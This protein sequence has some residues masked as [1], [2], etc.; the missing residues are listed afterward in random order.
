MRSSPGRSGAITPHSASSRPRRPAG[1]SWRRRASCSPPAATRRPDRADRRTAGVA[2]DTCTRRSAASRC[3]S[4]RSSRPH[5]PVRTSRSPRRSA[6]T[7][8]P[9]EPRRAHGEDRYLCGALGRIAPRLAPVHLALR[10]A[11]ARDPDCAALYA[12]L[13]HRRAGNMRLFAGDLRATGELRADLS[14]DEVADIVW[15]MASAEYYLLLV[16]DRPGRRSGSATTC[17]MPGPAC[18]LRTAM[19]SAPALRSGA[20]APNSLPIWSSADELPL[21]AD[22]VEATPPFDD[23]VVRD[24]EDVYSPQGEGLAVGGRAQSSPVRRP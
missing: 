2:V 16:Q 8:R 23:L 3:C 7:S 19:L 14:D 13:S 11:A 17:A 22:V 9:S 20:G 15:S 4:A 12:E 5:C 10:D 24:A 1:R 18:S 21:K 6:T